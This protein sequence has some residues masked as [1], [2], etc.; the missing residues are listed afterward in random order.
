M[1]CNQCKPETCTAPVGYVCKDSGNFYTT[2]EYASTINFF[3]IHG[4]SFNQ[5][6]DSVKSLLDSN[7]I[8]I[9]K[10][11]LT[12]SDAPAEMDLETSLN[13][14]ATLDFIQSKLSN[15]DDMEPSST[16]PIIIPYGDGD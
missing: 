12:E 15:V 10:V 14:I 9:L 7:T 13:V 1:T 8:Q 11:L 6:V 2:G 5:K 16:H 3:N 4:V